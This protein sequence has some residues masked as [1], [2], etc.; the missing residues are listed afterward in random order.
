MIAF[1]TGALLTG[2]GLGTAGYM[3]FQSLQAETTRLQSVVDKQK[4]RLEK[5]RSQ[6]SLLNSELSAIK[7][8]KDQTYEQTIGALM[9]AKDNASIEALYAIGRKALAEKDAPRAY[10]ALSQ[11][12]AAAPQYKDLAT[13]YPLAQ[14]A[15]AQH[16]QR[17]QQEQLNAAYARGLDQQAKGELAQAQASYREV[18]RLKTPFKD[19]KARLEAVTR[20]LNTRTQ[21]RELAQKNAWLA[22]TYKLGL[23]HQANGRFA[24]A[25]AAY[26][27]IVGYAPQYKDT[28]ARLKAVRAKVPKTVPLASAAPNCYAQG[29]LFGKCAMGAKDPVCSQINAKETPVACKND[30]EFIRGYQS[31]ATADPN[32]LLKGLSSFLK[33]ISPES[34]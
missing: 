10:F 18:L 28:A 13:H 32:G 26:A 7:D 33:D 17:V 5:L 20:Y 2:A 3:Q 34:E 24:D 31:T 21:T 11:V 16:Q 23:S 12:H 9:Q 22:S 1:L 29:T 6:Q 19:A 8:E 15:Y 27:Q 4:L 30:P 25:Q 14:Q